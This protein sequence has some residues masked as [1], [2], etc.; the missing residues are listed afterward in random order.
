MSQPTSTTSTSTDGQAPAGAEGTQTPDS[1]AAGAPNAD[2]AA[3]NTTDPFEG[4]PDGFAWVKDEIS[5][6]RRGEASYR[7][8]LREREAELANAKTPEEVQAVIDSFTSK[9]SDLELE[10]ARE[11]AIR[12]HKLEDAHLEFITG[13]TP[14]EISASAEKLRTLLGAVTPPPPPAPKVTQV[15]LSGGSSPSG[16]QTELDGR[17]AY[18]KYLKSSR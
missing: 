15:P 14:E 1:G 2:S 10:L 5:S 11:R 7:T 6:L 4:L 9:T 18:E 8:Q 3:G 16:E 12:T 13:S 17:A